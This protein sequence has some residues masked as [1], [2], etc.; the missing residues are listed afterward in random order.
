M[1][2]FLLALF[3]LSSVSASWAIDDVQILPTR[4]KLDENSGRGEKNSSEKSK[5]IIY[6]IKVT[7]SAFKELQN[8]TV[9]YNIFY[10]DAELGSNS[11][12]EVK[13]VAGASSFPSLL[14]NKPVDFETDAIQLGQAALDGGWYFKNGA[15]AVA[16]DK[17]V[18]VWIRAF[19]EAGKQIGQYSNPSSV[20]TKQKWK[21]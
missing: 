13:I 11:K 16:K 1:K 2:N 4:K 20:T 10:E 9:K 12:P 18:G 5:Q 15:K 3:V 8:T 19:D 6:S 7:N 14:P 17:V 21:E